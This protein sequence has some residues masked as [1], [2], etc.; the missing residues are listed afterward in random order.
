MQNERFKFDDFLS[1]S[2]VERFDVDG[3]GVSAKYKPGRGRILV[4]LLHA[5]MP[6]HAEKR[7]KFQ[8]PLPIDAPQLSIADPSLDGHDDLASGW[9]LGFPGQG[10]PEKILTLVLE[11]SKKIGST[12]RVYVGGSSGGF[13]CLMLSS[14]D[15]GSL[16]IS[17]C[18]QTNLD[19]YKTFNLSKFSSR[20]P[21]NES[22][23]TPIT[24]LSG[25]N[26]WERYRGKL[27]NFI[28]ILVSPGD[29]AHLFGQVV[30]LLSN[31]SPTEWGRVVVEVAFHG[32]A[33]HSSSV[34]PAAYVPW[35]KAA[36]LVDS[37]L[38][39]E[40]MAAKHLIAGQGAQ[41]E[42]RQV[43]DVVDFNQRDIQL[44]QVLYDYIMDLEQ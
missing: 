7:P 20:F 17:A 36:L 40:L 27:S 32:V 10:V 35:V 43:A 18:P 33:G 15:A 23:S 44:S 31:I 12:K 38:A 25:V 13:A 14:M 39:S 3:M 29:P 6:P 4:V 24:Q 16:A 8:A 22:L 26:L 30:P 21:G 34:P 1:G 42:S 11:F 37:F 9:Y 19:T 41:A 28:V 2:K 5:A